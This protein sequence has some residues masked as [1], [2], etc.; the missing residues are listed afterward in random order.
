LEY[1]ERNNWT[2]TSYE[3]KYKVLFQI[4]E[5]TFPI[6]I[7]VSDNPCKAMDYRLPN[8]DTFL[9]MNF[10]LQPLVVLDFDKHIVQTWETKRPYTIDCDLTSFDLIIRLG[11]ITGKAGNTSES[12]NPVSEEYKD[13]YLNNDLKVSAGC[14]IRVMVYICV[15]SMSG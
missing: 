1:D 14:S 7:A 12:L 11:A 13:F 2:L 5:T 8:I 3:G 10:L 9:G 4:G 15:T 6:T